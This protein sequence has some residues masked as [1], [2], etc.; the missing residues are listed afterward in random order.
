MLFCKQF[1]NS[2]PELVKMVLELVFDKIIKTTLFK[3]NKK[4]DKKRL[5]LV[6]RKIWNNPFTDHLLNQLK[7]IINKSI[8]HKILL[9]VIIISIS[10]IKSNK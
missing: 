7:V 3:R 1:F 10:I 2:D 6:G 5:K 9:Y 4:S 8:G